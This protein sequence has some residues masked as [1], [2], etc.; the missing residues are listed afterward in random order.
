MPSTGSLSHASLLHTG[1]LPRPREIS[2]WKATPPRTSDHEGTP[3]NGEEYLCNGARVHV[4]EDVAETDLPRDEHIRDD[5]DSSTLRSDRNA[6]GDV[7]RR[8]FN[9][10][11]MKLGTED[12]IETPP[13][14]SETSDTESDELYICSQFGEVKTSV[15]VQL[16]SEDSLSSIEKDIEDGEVRSPFAGSHGN[17]RSITTN[18]ME[19]RRF[20]TQDFWS[21]VFLD[22]SQCLIEDLNFAADAQTDNPD[23]SALLGAGAERQYVQ[24]NGELPNWKYDS[25]WDDVKIRVDDADSSLAIRYVREANCVWDITAS[26]VQLICDGGKLVTSCDLSP[27]DVFDDFCPTHYSKS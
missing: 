7:S 24:G 13:L 6:C 2:V 9:E 17:H 14:R 27:I 11:D 15:H 10:L 18:V 22:P 5:W 8:L 4:S 26:E 23:G 16:S 1:E 20:A 3:L 21:S 12:R 19:S 25:P